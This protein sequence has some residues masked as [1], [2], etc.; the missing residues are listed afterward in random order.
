MSI[1][2]DWAKD[3]VVMAE[4]EVQPIHSACLDLLASA[5]PG[6]TGPV[7]GDV[8]LAFHRAERL[9]RTQGA[10]HFASLDLRFEKTDTERCRSAADS[11]AEAQALLRQL[12]LN[13]ADD[14][15][16]SRCYAHLSQKMVPAIE[17]GLDVFRRLF[18]GM[19]LARQ[20]SQAHH[21]QEVVRKLDEISKQIYFVSIN[22]SIQAVRAGDE[23][24]GFAQVSKEIRNL[25]QSA[26]A[27]T[28]NLSKLM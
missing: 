5:Q 22:A 10:A 27:T 3:P 16:R 24:L 7:G 9:F 8:F 1:N 6:R 14:G 2:L 15:L 25:A 17:A 11:I 13:P 12:L 23:G 26:Q 21:A 4:K 19:V 18:L 20:N 28:Q